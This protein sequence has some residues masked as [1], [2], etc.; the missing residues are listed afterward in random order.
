[1]TTAAEKIRQTITGSP[2]GELH[3][4]HQGEDVVRWLTG[5][6]LPDAWV[7]FHRSDEH[8]IVRCAGCQNIL[9]SLPARWEEATA[10]QIAEIRRAGHENHKPDGWPRA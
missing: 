4:L 2:V 3:F 10:E 1:M 6:T 9:A 7:T 8:T 5:G